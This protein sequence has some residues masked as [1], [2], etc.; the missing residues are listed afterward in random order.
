MLDKIIT[1]IPLD[2]TIISSAVYIEEK[3][4]T[5]EDGEKVIKK[6]LVIEPSKSG[7]KAGAAIGGALAG[8]AGA[9]VGGV[10]GGIFGPSDTK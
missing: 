4:K 2:K 8:S 9:V 1:P 3:T 6:G 7:A 5:T 10:I